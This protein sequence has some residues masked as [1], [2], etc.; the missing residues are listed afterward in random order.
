[1]RILKEIKWIKLDKAIKYTVKVLGF[2]LIFSL[3]FGSLTFLVQ[4]ILSILL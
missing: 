3:I 4:N 1:M 2:T